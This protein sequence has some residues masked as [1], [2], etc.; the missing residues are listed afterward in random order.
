[1]LF[2][3]WI[4]VIFVVQSLLLVCGLL[5]IYKCQSTNRRLKAGLKTQEKELAATRKKIRD[6]AA[7][8]I[9]TEREVARLK[10]IPKAELLPMLQLTHELRSP[11]AAVQNSLEMILQGYTKADR[12]LHDEMLTLAQ[13][14]TKIMLARV[15]DFLRLGAVTYAEIERKP[16]QVQL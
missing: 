2:N 1:M 10:R 12:Y 6:Q 16:R 15:N 9:E 5:L 7:I 13:D 11:L 14:R 3:S 8:L 4:F